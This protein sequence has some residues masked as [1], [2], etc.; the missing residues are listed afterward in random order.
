MDGSS[1]RRVQACQPLDFLEGS[2]LIQTTE[3][4][5]GVENVA[6]G[7]VKHSIQSKFPNDVHMGSD[8]KTTYFPLIVIYYY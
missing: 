8:L 3:S 1:P 5:W 4:W 2:T 7:L 6:K